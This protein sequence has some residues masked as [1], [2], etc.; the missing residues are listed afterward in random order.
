[1][2]PLRKKTVQILLADSFGM[3]P[4]SSQA[5]KNK[6]KKLSPQC[7]AFY[8]WHRYKKKRKKMEMTQILL[9]FYNT[10]HE[11]SILKQPFK[12]ESWFDTYNKTFSQLGNGGLFYK[13]HLHIFMTNNRI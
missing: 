7:G 6:Q 8:T 13:M 10:E 4:S 5:Y 11:K 12:P 9:P 1:M 3:K 2:I